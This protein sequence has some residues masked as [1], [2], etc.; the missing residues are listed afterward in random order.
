[1]QDDIVK[2]IPGTENISY[3]KTDK[4]FKITKR[5][6][7][8]QNFLGSNKTLIGAL[9]IKD[10]CKVNNWKKYPKSNTKSK[11]PY[12]RVRDKSS[13]GYRYSV[14]KVINGTEYTFGSYHRLEEAIVRR[15][16]CVKN[17]WSFDLIPKDP[18]RFIEISLLSNG[19]LKYDVRH[20]ENGSTIYYGRFDNFV[21]AMRERD[22][23][24][25]YNWD[26]EVMCNLDER[27]NGEIIYLNRVIL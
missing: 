18:F 5:I 7:G 2:G 24:E 27:T 10:W 19:Q 4:V 9:M 14:A 11:E 15:D 20:K 21:D 16:Y 23:C 26:S 8:N 17:D 13:E 12:I 6:N 22:L 3:C 25:K 1:M